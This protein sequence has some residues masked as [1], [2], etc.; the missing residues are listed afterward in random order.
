MLLLLTLS[1]LLCA[2]VWARV[3]RRGAHTEAPI[4][5]FVASGMGCQTRIQ[6]AQVA[7]NQSPP[8]FSQ[9]LRELVR[10]DGAAVCAAPCSLPTQSRLPPST[11]PCLLYSYL[12]L[13]PATQSCRL[14]ECAV[15]GGVTAPLAAAAPDDL[16]QGLMRGV[17]PKMA[18]TALWSTC[19]V[20][21]YEFLKRLCQL[22]PST[23]P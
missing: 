3:L 17:V 9:T 6:V 22:E 1:L 20:S 11:P 5:E 16:L 10:Q 12:H 23:V 2:I 7:S 21:V 18:N 19:M 15:L 4:A 13:L 14:N 8:T